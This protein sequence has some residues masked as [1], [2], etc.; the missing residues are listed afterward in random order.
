MCMYERTHFIA[1][2][3]LYVSFQEIMNVHIFS[4][5]DYYI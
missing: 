1:W 4:I 3:F 2:V 5:G